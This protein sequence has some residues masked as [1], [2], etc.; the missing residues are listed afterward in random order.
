[1]Y[2]DL[3]LDYTYDQSY[4]LDEHYSSY[5]YDDLDEDYARDTQDFQELAYM[6]YA[7][8]VSARLAVKQNR[9]TIGALWREVHLESR[10]KWI[11]NLGRGKSKVFFCNILYFIINVAGHLGTLMCATLWT[12]TSSAEYIIKL[13]GRSDEGL[14]WVLPQ[15]C[16]YYKKFQMHVQCTFY[17]MYH[18]LHCIICT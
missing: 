17:T 2:D 13:R 11:D 12:G 3:S 6:H 16:P 14:K 9:T 7:W 5:D 8:C 18:I 15:T 4:D 1:M 10:A